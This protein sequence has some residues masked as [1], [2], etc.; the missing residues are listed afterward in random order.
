MGLK[1]DPSTGIYGM[2]F[3]VVLGRKGFRVGR[4]KLKVGRVGAPHRVT[5][6]DAIDWFQQKFEGIG[7]CG[8]RTRAG[9]GAQR[10]DFAVFS[11][12]LAV[13]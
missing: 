8:R 3:Y 4:R 12:S 9:D 2:D 13:Q 7:R 10:K 1:Y 6:K 11:L 5:Q